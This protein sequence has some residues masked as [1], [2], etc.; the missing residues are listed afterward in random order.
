MIR[1]KFGIHNMRNREGVGVNSPA[2][3]AIRQ[4]KRG[5]G[6]ASLSNSMRHSLEAGVPLATVS[7]E[8]FGAS[9]R[10]GSLNRRQLL[11]PIAS[12]RDF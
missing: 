3:L 8:V 4:G 5:T 1:V 2:P 7:R 11:C 6:Q 12:P 10:V 9:V